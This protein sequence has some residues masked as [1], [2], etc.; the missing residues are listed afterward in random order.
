MVVAGC[1]RCVRKRDHNL[2]TSNWSADSIPPSKAASGWTCN[3]CRCRVVIASGDSGCWRWLLK[4]VYW[5]ILSV[6]VRID[7]KTQAVMHPC[8][9]NKANSVS[10]WKSDCVFSMC[11]LQAIA[12]IETWFSRRCAQTKLTWCSRVLLKRAFDYSHWSFWDIQAIA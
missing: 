7:E 5:K 3:S 9:K 1:K 11:S 2:P 6:F 8:L 12:V 10:K 4:R